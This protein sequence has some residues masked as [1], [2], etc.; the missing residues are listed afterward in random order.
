M[1]TPQ[2]TNIRI[3]ESAIL[4]M[5]CFA[6]VGILITGYKIMNTKPCASFSIGVYSSHYYAGE[7]V[8]LSVNLP[9]YSKLEWDFGD[10]SPKVQNTAI[11]YHQF[12]SPGDYT[13][14]VTVDNTCTE[15]AS[16]TIVDA[17][18]IIDNSKLPTFIY[19][20]S[21]T[22][23]QPVK[24]KDTTKGATQWEWR[25]GETA[26]IDATS[27]EPSYIYTT[28]GLKTV[29]LVINNDPK[30]LA[31]VKVYVNPQ[32]VSAD[33]SSN[34]KDHPIIILNNAPTSQPIDSALTQKIQNAVPVVHKAPDISKDEFENALKEVADKAI[35]KQYFEQYFEDINKVH[36][37]FN[38]KSTSFN[39]MFD[40]IRTIKGSS[41]IK[42]LHVQLIKNGATNY[43]EMLN[44]DLKTKGGFLFFN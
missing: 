11:L 34:R 10:Q 24:F 41:R 28:P 6:I 12:D 4:M 8:K 9:A 2:R 14:R 21:A 27:K 38:G 20:T 35:P 40:K 43:I 15:Y 1:K 39:D 3:D 19:P 26:A 13:I 22:V 31:V 33:N 17:P 7:A 23:G 44:V 37:N 25:F 16:V 29:S 42:S 30:R 36:V 18:Q 32:K 5:L